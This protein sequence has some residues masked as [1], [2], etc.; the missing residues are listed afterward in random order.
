MSA[1]DW[2]CGSRKTVSAR[3]IISGI[4]TEQCCE[5]TARHASDLGWTV[6]YVMDATLTYDMQQPDGSSLSTPDIKART[7]TVLI[8]R[9]ATIYTVEQALQRATAGA[10]P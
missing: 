6:D 7:A 3:L 1:P 9:F 5:T 8:D 10:A 2:M 4:R